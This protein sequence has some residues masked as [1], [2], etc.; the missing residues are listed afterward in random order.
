[1]ANLYTYLIASLP[2]LHFG[3]KPPFSFERFLQICAALIPEK[4]YQVLSTL[5]QPQEYTLKSRQ[6]ET[7]KRWM[8]FDLALR[9][10]LVKIRAAKKHIDPGEYLRPDGYAG[11]SLA[12]VALAIQRNPSLIE[13]EKA[14]DLERWNALE[15][16]AFGHYFDLDFLITYAYKLLIL[17]RWDRI[18]SADKTTLLDKALKNN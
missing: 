1:M 12:P 14:L 16:L 7:I 6:Q 11:S 15:E 18:G 4:D 9:N 10:E 5:P 17:E 8:E 3:A 2:M 13:A